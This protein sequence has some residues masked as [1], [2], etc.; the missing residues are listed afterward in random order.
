MS[1]AWFI[2]G[3]TRSQ[4]RAP[5]AVVQVGEKIGGRELAFTVTAIQQN[6]TCADPFRPLKPGQ[7]FLRFDLDVTSLAVDR[8]SDSDAANS[9]RLRHWS[10]EGNDGVVEKDIYVYTKC[11]DGTEDISQPVVPGTHTKPVVV[12]NA[13]KPARFSG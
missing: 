5:S 4:E 9:L 12:I 6:A 7:Q 8:F 11:G 10:V 1:V 3:I 2:F 13:P